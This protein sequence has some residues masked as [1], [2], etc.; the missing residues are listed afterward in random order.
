MRTAIWLV[1]LAITIIYVATAL[2]TV[3]H[4]TDQA[5]INAVIAQ[6]VAA[7][8]SQ[9]LSGLVSCLSKDYKDD[10][11]LNYDRLRVVLAQ[12]MRSEANY[13]ITASGQT[14]HIDG[15]QATVKLHVTLKHPGEVFYDRDITVML[16][17]ENARHMLIVP[18]KTW[19]VV[20]SQNLGFEGAESG[21]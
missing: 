17:K 4:G 14:I 1:I 5:R 15:D 21:I 11:G 2:L 10:S 8:Q 7:T 3:E 12:A 6:G 9:D 16:A 20:G 18:I 13:T 19:R